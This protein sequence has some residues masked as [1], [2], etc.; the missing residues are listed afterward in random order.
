M[1]ATF[2]YTHDKTVPKQN[3][4]CPKCSL[5]SLKLFILLRIDMTGVTPVGERIACRDENIWVTDFKQYSKET[6][7]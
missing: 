5:P 4:L 3:G 1:A 6:T 2:V 7:K